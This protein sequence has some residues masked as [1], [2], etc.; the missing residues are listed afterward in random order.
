M[1][2]VN[3]NQNITDYKSDRR[4]VQ[5]WMR[6][7]KESPDYSALYNCARRDAQTVATKISQIH[8]AATLD[9][10][11]LIAYYN[12]LE[13]C[14]RARGLDTDI[15]QARKY[16]RAFKLAFNISYYA[17]PGG[18]VLRANF[19][20]DFCPNGKIGYKPDYAAQCGC[21]KCLSYKQAD[22]V[23]G[24][25]TLGWV[26]P[27]HD[28]TQF[29]AYIALPDLE[30]QADDWD[31][32]VGVAGLKVPGPTRQMQAHFISTLP[33]FN[34]AWLDVLG[35]LFTHY[36]I[37]EEMLGKP[38][39][40]RPQPT[41]VVDSVSGSIHTQTSSGQSDLARVTPPPATPKNPVE[42]HY[43]R[44]QKGIINSAVI[45]WHKA[46]PGFQPHDG[47]P[48]KS[49]DQGDTRYPGKPGDE[50]KIVWLCEDHAKWRTRIGAGFG[51]QFVVARPMWYTAL[52]RPELFVA[53]S[54]RVAKASK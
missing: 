10:F 2:T 24:G 31:C 47:R 54:V 3:F 49:N 9:E 29:T 7:F 26:Y 25:V 14:I 32:T 53:E 43:C 1:T 41:K 30:D 19:M 22:I 21:S 46:E 4:E 12:A 27:N 35:A 6:K 45:A 20:R 36:G 39:L 48:V 42:C 51:V 23:L 33:S 50:D 5:E 52:T 44:T 37:T 15:V 17:K 18:K 40:L 38:L 11:P 34:Q 16:T 28:A 8:P 13:A